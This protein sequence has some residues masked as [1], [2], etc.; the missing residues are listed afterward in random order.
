[1]RRLRAD[2]PAGARGAR[3]GGRPGQQRR[4]FHP[5]L[6][7]AA[8]RPLPRLRA[9]D[10][11]Q[12]LWR[13][14]ADAD[15]R[16]RDARA[17]FGPRDQHLRDRRAGRWPRGRRTPRR[18]RR[19]S[20]RRGRPWPSSFGASI[21]GAGRA[22]GGLGEGEARPAPTMPEPLSFLGAL[23]GAPSL[24]IACALL[25]LEEAGLPIP[26]APGEA[27]L[28]GCGLLVATGAVPAWVVIPAAYA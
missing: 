27:V 25:F 26:I 3:A 22:A 20:R 7:G 1:P 19:G 4:P 24:V 11:A 16:P 5:T 10:A 6:P 23:R 28:I 18:V 8:A 17:A 2:G 12:L 21:S 9:H 14:E 15:R 13:R